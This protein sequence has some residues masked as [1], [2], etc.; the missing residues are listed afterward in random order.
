MSNLKI[1]DFFSC[2]LSWGPVT[3]IRFVSTSR[4]IGLANVYPP[5]AECTITQ[6]LL[7]YIEALLSVMQK[8]SV[9][10]IKLAFRLCSPFPSAP[11]PFEWIHF[12]Y[13]GVRRCRWVCRC[14][15]FLQ[16]NK[17]S[18]LV[19]GV[20]L[21]WWWWFPLGHTLLWP[22]KNWV[23][24]KLRAPRVFFFF[25]LNRKTNLKCSQLC[26]TSA[27]ATWANMLEGD[28]RAPDCGVRS[29]GEGVAEG[30]RTLSSFKRC[31]RGAEFVPIHHRCALF[32][33]PGRFF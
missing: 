11:T 6:L 20:T 19:Y 18:E 5:Q 25:L 10:N 31:C 8:V 7:W 4:G 15:M 33:T 26:L 29:S 1:S 32:G 14:P 21:V 27:R 16:P 30:K 13:A 22:L 17:P 23:H 2:K 3:N 24:Y 28:R 9:P 12:L